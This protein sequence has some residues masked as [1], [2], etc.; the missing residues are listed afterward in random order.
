M[1]DIDHGRRWPRKK[2]YMQKKKMGKKKGE[3]VKGRRKKGEIKR[4]SRLLIER[5]Q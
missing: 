3:E 1:D 5:S 2:K 4:K